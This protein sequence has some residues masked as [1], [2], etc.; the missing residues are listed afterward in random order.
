MPTFGGF[1]PYP[2][3]FGGGRTRAKI[4]H[5][6]LVADRGTA[7][8]AANRDT[9]AYVED[10]AIARAIS[11]AWGTNERL[12]KLWDAERM[13]ASTISRWEKILALAPA[14]TDDDATRRGRIAALFARFGDP[15]IRTQV[16]DALTD[17]LGPAFYAV[18]YIDYSIATIHSPNP[19]Y[20]WGTY[21]ADAPWYSNVAT[22][23]V[24]LQRTA[25]MTEADFYEAAALVG[26]I[27]DPMLPSWANYLWYRSP[28]VG[29]AVAV[30]GGPSA[31]GFYLDEINLD[32]LVFDV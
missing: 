18:E 32:N 25:A 20:P 1:S 9:T 6:S 31:A 2:R 7:Y 21:L 12:A 15:A 8:D 23:L 10:L 29:A 28:S 11:A 22:I 13:A 24:R 5:E 19:M 17:A 16:V 3:R 30:S 26:A 4:I 14:A 27:L